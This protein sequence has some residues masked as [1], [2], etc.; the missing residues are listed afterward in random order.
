MRWQPWRSSNMPE[1]RTTRALT[2]ASCT[3]SSERS[4]SSSLKVSSAISVLAQLHMLGQSF[5]AGIK[6]LLTS[7]IGFSLRS[8]NATFA[9]RQFVVRHQRSEERRVGNGCKRS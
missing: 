8:N 9:Q 6:A 3:L 4:A 5:D 7:D 1:T 2:L